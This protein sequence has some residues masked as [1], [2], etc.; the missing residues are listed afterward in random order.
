MDWSNGIIKKLGGEARL[1][2]NAGTALLRLI[3]MAAGDANATK[4]LTSAPKERVARSCLIFRTDR[5]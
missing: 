5:R 2:A 3:P 4:K 1:V